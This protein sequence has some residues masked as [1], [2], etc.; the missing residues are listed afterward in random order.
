MLANVG[1]TLLAHDP[2]GERDILES[3]VNPLLHFRIGAERGVNRFRQREKFD[4]AVHPFGIFAEHNL[5]DR[6]ILAARVGDFVAAE[7]KRIAGITF[8]RAHV[9]MEIEQLTQPN[10]R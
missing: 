5:I 1:T 6:H 9:G 10:N 3:L 8:T 7:V 2:S 4:A